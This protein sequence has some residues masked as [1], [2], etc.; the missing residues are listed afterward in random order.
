MSQE[1][2]QKIKAVLDEVR[3]HLQMDGGDVEF[4]SFDEASGELQVKLQGACHNCPMSAMTLQGGIG[5]LVKEK[6][7]EVKEIKAI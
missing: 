2:E 3:P 4:V 6:V 1:L 7:K 5:H